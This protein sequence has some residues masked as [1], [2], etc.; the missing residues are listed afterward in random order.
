MRLILALLAMGVVA[1]GC[2]G[3]KSDPP[4]DGAGGSGGGGGTGGES[5]LGKDCGGVIACINRCDNDVCASRCTSYV[6]SGKSSDL[7]EAVLS[8]IDSSGCGDADRDACLAAACGDGILECEE[9]GEKPMACVD[10]V[11]CLT[12]C[13]DRACEGRCYQLASSEGADLL[14]ALS[15]CYEQKCAGSDD[16]DCLAKM[17]GREL[18]AC[19][20]D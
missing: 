8:C 2:G 6:R 11:S 4:S 10:L 5:P 17:C 15:A 13:S 9:D 16:Q 12:Y 3:S 7:L 20:S 19:K 14:E 1:V 18:A